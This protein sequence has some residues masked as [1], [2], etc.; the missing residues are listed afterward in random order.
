VTVDPNTAA[1]EGSTTP[2][3]LA[4]AWAHKLQQILPQVNY[5]KPGQPL[6][7]PNLKSKVIVTSELADVGGSVGDVTIGRKLVMRLRGVQTDGLTAAER[8]DAIRTRLYK[9][10]STAGRTASAP[11]SAAPTQRADSEASQS[12]S[13]PDTA[14]S[15]STTPPAALQSPTPVACDPVQVVPVDPAKATSA[16]A[17][18]QL[19]VDGQSIIVIDKTLAESENQPDPAVLANSWAKNIRAVLAPAAPSAATA[20]NS[21]TKVTEAAPAGIKVPRQ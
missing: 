17:P 11:T 20:P 12:A 2:I 18:V 6:P 21:P 5:R 16:D 13:V 10:I 19:V 1:V 8:A 14:N 3:H 7:D 15:A 4:T 9:A